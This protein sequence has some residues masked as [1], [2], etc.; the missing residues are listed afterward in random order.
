M[1]PGIRFE[2]GKIVSRGPAPGH[3][4]QRQL[5]TC[6]TKSV[7]NRMGVSHDLSSVV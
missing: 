2:W 7:T 3:G 4:H 1:S 5:G 6:L